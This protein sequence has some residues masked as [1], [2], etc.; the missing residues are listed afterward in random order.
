MGKYSGT[1]KGN[2]DFEIYEKKPSVEEFKKL[3]ED[4]G[5]SIPSNDDAKESL[6]Y[7][8]YCISVYHLNKI[9]GMV[10]ITGDKTMYGYIQDL[11]VLSEYQRQGIGKK[12]L[13][14]LLDNI[15]KEGYLIGVCPSKEATEL[16]QSFGFKKR[17]AT[18]NGFMS[19]GVKNVSLD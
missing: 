16:Y 9:V 8:P 17:P 12:M 19:M 2:K 7:S 5:W 18:P 3:R 10:R 1:F 4:A 6:S 14:S 11:I 13:E 15:N